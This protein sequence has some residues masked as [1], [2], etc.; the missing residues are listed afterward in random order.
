VSGNSFVPI[1]FHRRDRWGRFEDPVVAG[2]CLPTWLAIGTQVRER[3][4]RRRVAEVG[5]REKRVRKPPEH[6]SIAS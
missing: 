5:L 2:P 1:R 6:R 4:S 3:F